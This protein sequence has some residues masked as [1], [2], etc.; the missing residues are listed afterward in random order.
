[1]PSPKSSVRREGP[2]A[3]PGVRSVWSAADGGLARVRIPGGRLSVEQARVLATAAEELG[4]GV[5]EL[6]SRANV[7]IRGLQPAGEHALAPR[8][9][10]AGL[11]P[12]DTHDRVRNIVASPLSGLREH[13]DVGPIVTDLD[14]GLCDDPHLA[15]LPGRFLFAIDDGSLDVSGLDADVTLHAVPDGFVVRLGGA[16]IGLTTAPAALALA[17]ARAF[18]AERAAQHSPAWRLAELAEGPARVAARL[19]PSLM[20]ERVVEIRTPDAGKSTPCSCMSG[21]RALEPGEY[22]QAD[23]RTALVLDA[24]DGRLTA[25]AFRALADQA[26]QHQAQQHQAQQHRDGPAGLRV[27]P[28]RGVVLPDL[29]PE[30]VGTVTAALAAFGLHTERQ[31]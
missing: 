5:L 22:R 24:G 8:L 12:S 4:S 1:M 28:W 23:G 7:Q 18:L 10:A 16:K 3:C 31:A 19:D 20:H 30:A 29:P 14:E 6:T 15:A 21:A 2:D 27:T 17:A 9:R 13:P 25:A 26:Q 11:L